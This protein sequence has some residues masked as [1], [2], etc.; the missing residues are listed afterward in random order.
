VGQ[1]P[2]YR[3]IRSE[4]PDHDKWFSVEAALRGQI[5]GQG[6][7]TSKKAAE[8]DAAKKALDLIEEKGEDLLGPP[9][10]KA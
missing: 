8:Q 5:L 1:I 3:V 6:E 7:G 10:D 4:G 2:R 9:S